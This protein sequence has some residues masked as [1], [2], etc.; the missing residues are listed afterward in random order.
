VT[1]Q[2]STTRELGD[3]SVRTRITTDG[4]AET[5]FVEAGAGSG[6]TTVLVDRIVN[7]I[8]HE[9]VAPQH[10]AAITFTEAAAAELRDRIRQRLEE[11]S[12]DAE[13]DRCT[14][15][16]ADLDRAAITT[17]HGFALRVLTEHAIDAGLPPRVAV[18]DEV[19]SQLRQ[20]Q[21]WEH[22]VDDLYDEPDHEEVLLRA[23]ALGILLESRSAGKATLAGV[24][25]TLSQ[26]WDRLDAIV[27]TER[28]TLADIDFGPYDH[29]VAELEALLSRCSDPTDTLYLRCHEVLPALR[30]LVSEPAASIKVGRFPAKVENA[31]WKRGKVKGSG[32]KW[33]GDAEDARAVYDRVAEAASE[34]RTR[35]SADALRVLVWLIASEVLRAAE[36]RRREGLLEFHDLLVHARDLQRVRVLELVEEEVAIA[37]VQRSA[38]APG[39]AQQI[40]GVDEK[41][42][43]LEQPFPASLLGGTH[44][45]AGDQPH[46][47]AQHVGRR[48]LANLSA[49]IADRADRVDGPRLVATP[50]RVAT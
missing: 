24:A 40:A 19:T 8:V 21:R 33:G 16:L 37:V 50:R 20:R 30:E 18:L 5:L 46:E 12:V 28:P 38:G 26:S 49:R 43:E 17:L 41:V 23:H 31:A 48:S 47:H 1:G 44:H 4:L 13:R 10:V 27:A 42:V 9:G 15:A 6:K 29:A 7:L 14:A 11:R 32:P 36:E 34:I 25:A 45:F 3:E 35:A 39:P 2:I 22:F